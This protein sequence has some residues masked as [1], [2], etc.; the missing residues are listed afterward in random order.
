[1]VETTI[2]LGSLV[3]FFATI[4]NFSIHRVEEGHVAVYYRVNNL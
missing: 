1:M 3:T 2:I 4:A